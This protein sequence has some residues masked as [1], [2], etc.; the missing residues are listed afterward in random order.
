MR[1]D[2]AFASDGATLRGWLYRPDKAAAPAPAIVMAHGFSATKEMDLPAFAEVFCKAGF[3]V[4]LYDHRNLGASDG[5]PRGE[6]DPWQQIR[7]Y[8]DA[9]TYAQTLPGIDPARIG[10]WGSS[11]SG[12]HVIVV[13]AIDR[14]VKCVVSQVP[15]IDGYAN[16]QRQV[17]ADVIP[18]LQAQF[19]AD[20]V[21]RFR[22][23]PPAMI[24]VVA[25]KEGEPGFFQTDDCRKF[26][27]GFGERAATWRNLVTLRSIEMVTEYNP[28]SFVGR[29]SP[30]PLLMAVGLGDT[31]ALADIALDAYDRARPPKRLVTLPCNHFDPYS[32]P[33]FE[34]NV[35]AQ[36]AWFVAHLKP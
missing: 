1:T 12:G 23:E 30:T 6:I 11:Y 8:R 28:G 32:G 10:I 4:L 36:R 22:G 20:R 35:T 3:A 16:V 15:L 33:L 25:G 34:P 9:I 17:R 29:I 19:D 21:A 26:F 2:I 5:E 24:P 7:G 18:V 27:L 14:R 31:L 13:G